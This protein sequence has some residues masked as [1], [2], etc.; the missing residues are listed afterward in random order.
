MGGW[1]PQPPAPPATSRSRQDGEF[2]HRGEPL[3]G[4]AHVDHFMPPARGGSGRPDSLALSCPA[5]NQ[6]KG[7]WELKPERV[8]PPAASLHPQAGPVVT[9]DVWGR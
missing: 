4:D 9:N 2:L 6:R 5:C 8:A 3:G 1:E 7:S